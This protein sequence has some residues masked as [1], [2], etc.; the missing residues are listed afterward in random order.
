[1]REL[2]RVGVSSRARAC[3]HFPFHVAWINHPSRPSGLANALFL[4]KRLGETGRGVSRIS[5][6]QVIAVGFPNVSPNFEAG[7]GVAID[8]A[9]SRNWTVRINSETTSRVHARDGSTPKSGLK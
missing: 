9:S 5:A 7:S 1:M 6:I 2:E 4:L 3:R 8:T